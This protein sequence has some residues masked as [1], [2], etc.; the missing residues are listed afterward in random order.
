MENYIPAEEVAAVIMEPIQGDAGII[1][2]PADYVQGL[3]KLCKEN[4]ILFVSEE[5]QQGFGRT[6]RWFGHPAFRR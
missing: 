6:G 4:G 1:V 3:V 5:V 2:P